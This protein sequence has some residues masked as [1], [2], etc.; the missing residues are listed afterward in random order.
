[1]AVVEDVLDP[2]NPYTRSA[3][4]LGFLP[5]SLPPVWLGVLVP[6]HGEPD[7]N[8]RQATGLWFSS[9]EDHRS[10]GQLESMRMITA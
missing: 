2:T 9:P 6:E 8:C 10:I 3:L 7:H 5:G 1:V 4:L